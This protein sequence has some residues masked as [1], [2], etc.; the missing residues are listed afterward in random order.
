VPPGDLGYQEVG[1]LGLGQLL[2]QHRT[3]PLLELG[4]VLAGVLV[5]AESPLV[6]EEG[7]QVRYSAMSSSRHPWPPAADEGWDEDGVVGGDLGCARRQAARVGLGLAQAAAARHARLGDLAPEGRVVIPRAA[8]PP[9]DP[10]CAA[11]EGVLAVEE[12]PS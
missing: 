9:G 4:V 1:L 2:A 7:G 3:D 6:A 12:R 11:L 10:W 8:A 5:R